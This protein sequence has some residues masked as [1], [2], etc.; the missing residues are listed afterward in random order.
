MSKISMVKDIETEAS[1]ADDE[2]TK[3]NHQVSMIGH[4]DELLKQAADQLDLETGCHGDGGFV[5]G[6]AQ[7]RM[8]SN[9]KSMFNNVRKYQMNALNCLEKYH[10]SQLNKLEIERNTRLLLNPNEKE[11][12]NAYFDQQKIVIEQRI[13]S[14]LCFITQNKSSQGDSS[15]SLNTQKSVPDLMP[16]RFSTE[17]SKSARQSVMQYHQMN[18]LYMLQAQKSSGPKSIQQIKR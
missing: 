6:D 9:I 18:Q 5:R 14:N 7:A 10:E 8:S 17:S 12:I 16:P 11:Q 15:G 2:L 4:E 1:V 3:S 13:Y